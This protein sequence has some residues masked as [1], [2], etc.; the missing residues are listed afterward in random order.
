MGKP[1]RAMLEALVAGKT[2]PESLAGLAK[3][4]LKKKSGQLA[5]ALQGLIG[6]H[7]IPSPAHLASWA[8]LCPG[9]NE[10]AGKRKS[11][12]TRHGNPHLRR[13][14]AEAANSAAHTKD[15]Y[16]SAQYHRI[17][18]RRGGKRAAVAVAHTMLAIIYHML[19]EGTV[20]QDM[21]SKYFDELNRDAVARRAIKRL[22]ALGYKVTVE[23]AA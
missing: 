18:A 2:D 3:G 21:G 4:K 12:R 16:L 10:S 5:K 13:A 23:A 9:N 6:P 11:G 8:G 22:E 1:G 20:Y 17:A 14:L 15:Q 7:Q 19:K